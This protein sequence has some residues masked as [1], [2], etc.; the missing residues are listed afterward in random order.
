MNHESKCDC[1]T[2]HK[3]AESC[4]IC[5]SEARCN[6]LNG[7]KNRHVCKKFGH[8]CTE[9]CLIIEC[10]NDCTLDPGHEDACRCSSFHP[11][12]KL[13]GMNK[14]CGQLCKFDFTINHEM[15]TCEG[16]CPFPC[17]FEDGNSC[18]SMNHFH[19]DEI[20]LDA[21]G[22]K[23]LCGTRHTCKF[24]C[25]Q[26]GV[27]GIKTVLAPKV[28]KNMYNEFT[29][30]YVDLIAERL[31]C[32]EIIIP[33]EISHEK[34]KHICESTKHF[35][36][37]RCPDCNCFCDLEYA[38]DGY[39]SSNSHRNK[40]CSEYIATEK[41]FK[42][43]F[44]CELVKT[45]VTYIAGDSATPE[46]CDQYCL[47]KNRGHTHPIPCKGGDLCLSK[48]DIGFAI[49][50]DEKF[51]SG[52]KDICYYDFVTCDT[53][54]K[55]LG[56]L[57]PNEKT[58]DV[59]KI[60]GKCNFT[61]GHSLHFEKGEEVFCEASLF[62]SLSTSY[63]DHEFKCT[64]SSS[65]NHDIVFIIDCTGSMSS[66]FPQVK[67]VIHNLM[68]KWGDES[69]K[70]AIV[71]YTDH[72]PDNGHMPSTIPVSIYPPSKRLEDGDATEA[73]AFINN[74]QASGGGG[75]GGEALID[76]LSEANKL[77]FRKDTGKIYILVCDD[78]PHGDEFLRCSTYPRGCPCGVL[79][80]DLLGFMKT[81]N[82]NFIFVKLSEILNKTVELFS[83]VYGQ[84]MTVM[85]LNKVTDLEVEVTKTVNQTIEKNFVF[86]KKFRK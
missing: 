43:V 16:K 35:C 74:M 27:C 26:K 82:V 1:G 70:F 49:H 62:H 57:P 73:A 80:R 84:R 68:N 64:H 53:Y 83:E 13:C 86:S 54:W 30:P 12:G 47:T 58:P 69:N 48:T 52:S 19:D 25:V 71:G 9:K 31:K 44:Q 75:N 50:S 7:H 81:K 28:Y 8:K 3:C 67:K 11:C 78:S 24:E 10:N 34:C 79:W 46:I 21:C 15:H 45:A 63:S 22:R 39:H 5:V 56:W 29:Y 23:H 55:K 6:L 65:T 14:M 17:V 42:S 85:P 72:S 20:R 76:G 61:C 4:S 32:K 18:S 2:D 37:A 33:G 60:F 40:D 38:H 36:D 66:S 59:Q 41:I 77:Q 51:K